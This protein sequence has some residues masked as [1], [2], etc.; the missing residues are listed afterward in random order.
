[1]NQVNRNRYKG[2]LDVRERYVDKKKS[3]FYFHGV[4]K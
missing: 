4:K 2:K 1:M 3:I